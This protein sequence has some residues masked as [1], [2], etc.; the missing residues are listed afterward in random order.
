MMVVKNIA[1]ENFLVR[2]L[3]HDSKKINEEIRIHLM[4]AYDWKQNFVAD[5]MMIDFCVNFTLLLYRNWWIW[6]LY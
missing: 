3:I 5:A 4:I 2:G 6:T 1:I